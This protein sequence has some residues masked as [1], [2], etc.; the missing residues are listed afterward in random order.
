[1]LHE[2]TAKQAEF[3]HAI[4]EAL[5]VSLEATVAPK[6]EPARSNFFGGNGPTETFAYAVPGQ[7]FAVKVHLD[8]P[9]PAALTLQRMWIQSPGERVLD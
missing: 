9:A 4:L 5:G 3:Q 6:R 1:M 7:E 2:L 8:N